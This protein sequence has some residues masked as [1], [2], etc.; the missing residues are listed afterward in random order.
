MRLAEAVSEMTMTKIVID[1]LCQHANVMES[2]GAIR[3][4]ASEHSLTARSK[5]MLVR[6][7]LLQR[8]AVLTVRCSVWCLLFGRNSEPGVLGFQGSGEIRDVMCMNFRPLKCLD[9]PVQAVHLCGRT[10]LRSNKI[11]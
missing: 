7:C 4:D 1:C 8:L 2:Y 3:A 11:K 9:V 6:A 5:T 10:S